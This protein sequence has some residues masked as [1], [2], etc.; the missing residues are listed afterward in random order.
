MATFYMKL[1]FNERI[2]SEDGFYNILLNGEKVGFNLDL[3]LNYY[4]GF[5]LSSVEKLE[6]AIDGKV[7]PN[8]L[9]LGEING[10]KFTVDQMRE[11]Y[12]EYWGIKTPM[13]LQVFNG[14][15][16]E[17]KHDVEVSLELKNPSMYFE[18]GNYGIVDSSARKTLNVGKAR[19]L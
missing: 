4:R 13:H 1:G 5:P 16:S 3:R 11:Q 8:N 2:I 15:L 9:I 14:G 17:G 6:V 10:R 18:S 7:I 12:A 19:E